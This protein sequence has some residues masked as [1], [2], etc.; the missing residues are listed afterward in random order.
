MTWLKLLAG[1]TVLVTLGL[2]LALW[3][4]T[5]DAPLVLM[6]FWLLQAANAVWL[7]RLRAR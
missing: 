2:L 7:I 1:L 5:G 6:V 3:A 4:I